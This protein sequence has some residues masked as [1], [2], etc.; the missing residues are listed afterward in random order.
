MRV[1]DSSNKVVDTYLQ[2]VSKGRLDAARYIKENLR[3]SR[4][5]GYVQPYVP[6][7]QPADVRPVWIPAHKSKDSIDALVSG[8]WVYVVVRSSRWFIDAQ[9]EEKGKVAV[10]VPYKESGKE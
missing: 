9:D 7:V 8:H 4:T 2:A 6:V 10:I 5:F 3:L 1:K